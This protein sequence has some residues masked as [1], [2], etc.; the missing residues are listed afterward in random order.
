M[1]TTDIGFER[2]EEDFH[3]I[4]DTM[5]IKSNVVNNTSS[6]LDCS[7]TYSKTFEE[8]MEEQRK[9]ELAISHLESLGVEVRIK[10]GGY[11]NIYNVLK[12]LGECL[13]KKQKNL[14]VNNME[15]KKNIRIELSE[16]DVK[17][18]IADYLNREGYTVTTDD[19][20]ISV[21]SRTKGYGMGEY[22][23]TYF[24]AAYANCKEK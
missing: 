12:D 3:A 13:D 2:F 15:I 24:K 23:E 10:Y 16:S 22:T 21:S 20:N 11:R 8:E 5:F 6:L 9:M 17:E 1:K 7:L 4:S 14:K 19:V 18:I